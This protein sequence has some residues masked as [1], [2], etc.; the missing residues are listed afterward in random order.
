VGA[1]IG[2]GTALAALTLYGVQAL[3][4][5]APASDT[6]VVSGPAPLLLLTGTLA[7]LGASA[8]VAWLRLRPVE[9]YYRRGGLALVS[10][11]GTFVMAVLATPLH[12]FFGPAALL[13]LAAAAG[14][15]GFLLLRDRR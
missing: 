12:H 2:L 13:A 7:A 14:V 11:F 1:A 9:S 10:A 8:A 5:G 4:A 6:P 15:A 3:M